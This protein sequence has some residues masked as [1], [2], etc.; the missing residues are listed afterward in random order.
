MPRRSAFCS[1]RSDVAEGVASRPR[2]VAGPPSAGDTIG[3]WWLLALVLRYSVGSLRGGQ[4]RKADVPPA[5]SAWE[6]WDA[7]TSTGMKAGRAITSPHTKPGQPRRGRRP[8]RP[9]VLR[10]AGVA[11]AKGLGQHFLTDYAYV[12]RIIAAAGL[13]SEDTVIE[14][15]PGLGVL[16]EGLAGAAGRVIA[17]ELDAALA[18]RL[19]AQSPSLQNLTVVQG[20]ALSVLPG[21]LMTAAAFP[22]ETPYVVVGN[23]PY[24]VGT[25]IVRRFL[26]SEQPPSRLVVM[27]QREVAESVAAPEGELGLL[28]V[29]VQVYATARKLFNVPPRAFYPP[30]AVTSAVVRLDVRTAP[31]VPAEEREAFFRT[32]RAGFAAPR[33]QLRNTLAQGLGRNPRQVG[34]AIE[35]AGL[36]GSLRPQQLGVEDWLRLTRR[37][38]EDA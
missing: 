29:S 30:P 12:N 34:D 17:L 38:A 11:P 3:F 6:S 24:N 33:K 31:L 10:D 26:E 32:V 9:R 37:L 15:G 19:Q 14:V 13:D 8:Y 27:L 5:K 35:Q 18:R 23:L 36:V 21:E 25:A 22:G 16:T 1:G 20:D 7:A 28:G 2:D 4:Y